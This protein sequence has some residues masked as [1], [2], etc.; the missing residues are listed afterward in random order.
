MEGVGLEF[1][2]WVSSRRAGERLDEVHGVFHGLQP[3]RVGKS[4]DI[5]N[6]TQ[7]ALIVYEAMNFGQ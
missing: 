6:G 5:N 4:I 7:P 3:S 1:G 2:D